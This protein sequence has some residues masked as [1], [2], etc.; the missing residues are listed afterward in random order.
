MAVAPGKWITPPEVHEIAR[1]LRSAADQIRSV[2]QSVSSV[3]SQL[4]GS[5][6]GN[7]KNVFDAHFN[8]FPKEIMAYATRLDHMAVEVLNIQVWIPGETD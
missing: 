7:A 2:Y 6:L 1:E 4:D 8:G 3:E 5:W